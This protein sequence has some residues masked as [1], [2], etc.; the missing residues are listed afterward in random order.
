MPSKKRTLKLYRL[1]FTLVALLIAFFLTEF[2]ELEEIKPGEPPLLYSNVCEG[3]LEDLFLGAVQGAH[4]SVLLIIYSLTDPKLIDALNRQANKG[5]SI[6][7]FHDTT[8]PLFSMTK[9]SQCIDKQGIKMSGLMHQKILVV[10]SEKVWIGSANMTAESLK[11]HDNLVVGLINADL[12]HAI[13]KQHP[14]FSFTCGG[15]DIEYWSFP[16]KGKEGLKRLIQLIDNAQQSIRVAM[17]TWTHPALSEAIIRAHQRG[18]DVDI[19]LDHGQALGVCHQ[20]LDT[21]LEAGVNTRLSTGLGLLHHKFAWIDE[22]ILINGSANWTLAAFTRNKD[23]FLILHALSPSQN[24]TLRQ[25]WKRTKAA[26]ALPL[27]LAA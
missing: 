26:S 18:V 10:D 21:L 23:C 8:T 24:A 1:L 14:F 17:F 11:V 9:L 13:E 25:L 4:R 27:A 12:A 15:Q 6:K 5:V 20:A 19:I 22:Q 7:I 3:D 2:Q 16:Q